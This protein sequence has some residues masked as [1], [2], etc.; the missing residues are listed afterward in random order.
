LNYLILQ[1][2]QPI[3]P[4]IFVCATRAKPEE[5][6]ATPTGQSIARIRFSGR[7]KLALAVNNRAGLPSVY[8]RVIQESFR[9]HI[10]VF[11]HDDVWID[12]VF[13]VNH[14]VA[15]LSAYDVVGVAG[16][17]RLLP[18][19]PAWSFK[20]DQMEWDKGNLSG[21]VSHGPRPCGVPSVYGPVPAGVAL[22]DGVL[23]AAKCGTLLDAGVRFD[24]RFDFHFYDLD[25]SRS[26][27]QAGLKLGTFAAGIT[28]VSGGSFG[29][30]SWKAGLAKYRQKWPVVAPSL[31]A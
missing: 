4:V 17:R 20:N 21:V 24:E 7:I 5:F 23:L 29:S 10:L 13:F 28:H 30:P 14:L 22:L 19:A 3:P 18:E 12:D 6:A 25:F 1:I 16:N 9:D 15:G 27:K 2:V 11:V 26:A 31:G 8:N